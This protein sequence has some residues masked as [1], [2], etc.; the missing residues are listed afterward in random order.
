[1]MFSVFSE[2]VLKNS[3]KKQKSNIPLKLIF[4]C[5]SLE[6]NFKFSKFAFL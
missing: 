5:S 2:N 1:M 4:A 3:F 6:E